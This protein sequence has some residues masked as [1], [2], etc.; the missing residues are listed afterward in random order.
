MTDCIRITVWL[1][2]GSMVASLLN[3]FLAIKGL[4]SLPAFGLLFLFQLWMCVDAIRRGEWMWAVF[5]WIFPMM[6][7]AL[8]Y[9]YVYRASSATSGFELPGAAK[10]KRIKELEAQIH[11]LDNAVHHFQLGDIYFRQGKF[12]KAERVIARRWSG[13]RRTLMRGRIWD[14]ACCG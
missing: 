3:G 4:L 2:S 9:F 8:Y 14:S 5:I 1:S 12:E 10:R 7:A 13:T 11:H 6:N